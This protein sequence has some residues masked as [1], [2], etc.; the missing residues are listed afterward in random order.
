MVFEESRVLIRYSMLCFA[1]PLNEKLDLLGL[2][3]IIAM[4]LGCCLNFSMI[5]SKGSW[6]CSTLANSS[7]LHCKP[8]DGTIFAKNLL[9]VSAT[10]LL[11]DTILV[12]SLSK[13]NFVFNSIFI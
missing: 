7:S 9:N 12:F 3:F 11:L 8:R 5:F 6:I 13:S 1:T 4:I 2:C 10:R